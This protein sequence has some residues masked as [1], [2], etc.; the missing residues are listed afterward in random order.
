MPAQP[1]TFKTKPPDS[2][3]GGSRRTRASCCYLCCGPGCTPLPGTLTLGGLPMA[4]LHVGVGLP[5]LT[6]SGEK[7]ETARHANGRPLVRVA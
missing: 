3:T 4:L 6:W 2:N 1:L 5:V 7:G